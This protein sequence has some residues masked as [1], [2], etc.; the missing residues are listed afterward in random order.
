MD[1]R[2]ITTYE[3]ANVL[4]VILLDNS[5]DFKEQQSF[6]GSSDI[7]VVSHKRAHRICSGKFTHL[8]YEFIEID[9]PIKEIIRVFLKRNIRCNCSGEATHKAVII[10]LFV[11]TEIKSYYPVEIC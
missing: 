5:K 10:V 6:T 4:S 11:L 8:P 1:E 3:N 7:K 2:F 9:L